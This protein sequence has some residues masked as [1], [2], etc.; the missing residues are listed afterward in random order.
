MEMT[1]PCIPELSA[2]PDASYENMNNVCVT[3]Y[4][5]WES[6]AVNNSLRLQFT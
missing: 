4:L 2:A 3:V 5:V 6:R 1:F